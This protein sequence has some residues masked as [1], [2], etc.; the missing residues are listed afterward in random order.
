MTQPSG[1]Q[2]NRKTFTQSIVILLFF[3]LLAGVLTRLIPAGKYDRVEQDGV[4]MVIPGS[5]QYTESPDYPVWRWFLAPIEALFGPNG[6]T[7]LVI[8][9]FLLMV[10]VAFAVLDRSGILQE[11]LARIVRVFK[12]RKYML[13]LGISFFFMLIGAFF[14]IFEE[15]IP[16]VPLIVGLSY[17]L[18]W[19]VLV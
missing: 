19:D 3:M 16:L 6:L 8:I 2:I 13:L 1:A 11:L 9:L 18:G 12:H 10:G 7:I 17:F 5:F 4:E 15:V 14:G